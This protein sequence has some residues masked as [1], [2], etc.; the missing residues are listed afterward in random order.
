M[1]EK[2]PLNLT[3]FSSGT[4]FGIRIRDDYGPVRVYK[5]HCFFNFLFTF[6]WSILSLEYPELLR[7]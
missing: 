4:L 2:V 1:Y 5:I 3:F 6:K 7:Q